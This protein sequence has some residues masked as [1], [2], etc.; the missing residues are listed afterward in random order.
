MATLLKEN[1]GVFLFFI[2]APPDFSSTVLIIAQFKG[3]MTSSL[4]VYEPRV[5]WD[6]VKHQNQG[7][8]GE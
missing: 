7:W 3:T 5:G 1:M 2:P 6:Y 8:N 4:R